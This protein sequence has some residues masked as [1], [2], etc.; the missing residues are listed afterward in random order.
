MSKWIIV[1]VGCIECGVGSNV[2]GVFTDEAKANGIADRLNEGNA[3]WRQGGQN[4]YE[5][6]PMPKLNTVAEEYL[7]YLQG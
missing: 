6:F 4:S 2:V 5:V 3:S 1:N 7:E